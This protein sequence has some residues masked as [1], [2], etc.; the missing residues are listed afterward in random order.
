MIR[1]TYMC[2]RVCVRTRVNLGFS[3]SMRPLMAFE[4]V[5]Y[6]IIA[7]QIDTQILRHVN[8]S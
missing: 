5:S 7:Q 3:D 1:R 4:F 8:H 6:Y 2:I